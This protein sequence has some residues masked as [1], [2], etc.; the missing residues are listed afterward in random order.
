MVAHHF[1]FCLPLRL[2]AFL[3]SLCQLI[4]VGLLAAAGWYALESM[5]GHLPVHL[6]GAFIFSALYYSLLSITA[7]IGLFGTIARNAGLLSTYAYYLAWS[8]GVQ[9]VIDIIQLILF[10]TQSRQTLIKNCIDGST[11]QEIQNI[12]N[13]S[14]NNSKWSLLVSMIIGLIIQLWAAYIVSSYAKKL[15]Q[16]KSWRSGRDTSGSKYTHVQHDDHGA[17]V[18]LS[19]N[20]PYNHANNSFAG[21]TPHYHPTS[22]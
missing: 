7:L 18:P 16:E 8:T 1:C 10:F 21:S 20:Y 6:K 3:I 13:N 4:V 14:F 11:D 22:V 5:R 12:C 2:G 9:A 19:Y 17:N 15:E